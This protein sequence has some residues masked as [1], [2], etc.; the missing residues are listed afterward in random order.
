[1]WTDL[2]IKVNGET[3]VLD[4]SG[5]AW[6]PR[7]STLILADLHLEKGSSYAR[8]GQFQATDSSPVLILP[9]PPKHA[10]HLISWVAQMQSERQ[11]PSRI[12][13]ER[14]RFFLLRRGLALGIASPTWTRIFGNDN[15]Q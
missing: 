5:A 9:I 3:L 14:Q 2:S 12:M 11:R 15:L 7:V 10:L 8:F 6:W 1:M 13:R 4:K